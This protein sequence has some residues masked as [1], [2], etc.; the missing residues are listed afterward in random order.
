MK[1]Y[2]YLVFILPKGQISKLNKLYTMR[3]IKRESMLST[4]Q[5]FYKIITVPV[6]HTTM[7]IGKIIN[8][9]EEILRQEWWNLYVAD[10]SILAALKKILEENW[11]EPLQGIHW[12]R[13]IL[14]KIESVS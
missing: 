11:F 14:R 7:E 10:Y 4:E 9:V 6:L 3:G 8:Q 5:K 1:N 2:N 13:I 12:K